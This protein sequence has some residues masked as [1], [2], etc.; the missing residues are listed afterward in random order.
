MKQNFDLEIA[1]SKVFL[2]VAN[3]SGMKAMFFV[4][5]ISFIDNVSLFESNPFDLL[6]KLILDSSCTCFFA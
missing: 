3:L 5:L 1:V 4:T 6:I 2:Y